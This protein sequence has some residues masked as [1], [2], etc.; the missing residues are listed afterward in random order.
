[1]GVL[2]AGQRAQVLEGWNDTRAAVPDATLPELFQAQAART[3]DAIAVSCGG[4][5]LS[6]RELNARANRLARVL[7]GCGAGP[8][9]V[10]AVAM[11]RSA[12]LV[13]AL[14]AVLK[15]GAAYLPVHEGAPPERIRWMLADAGARLLLAD[16]AVDQ[17]GEGVR[18]VSTD[19]RLPAGDADLEVAGYSDQLA[20]VMY[21]SGSTGRPKG[22]AVRDRD[23]V[24][25]A[26]DRCWLGNAHDRVLMHSPPAF[27]ASTY[28][29][30][31]P[32]LSG[33]TV[34]VQP[35]QLDVASLRWLIA[36]EGAGALFLTPALFSLVVAEQPAALAGVNV[37][38]TGGEL[39]SPQA[40]ERMLQSCPQAIVGHVYGPTEATTFATSFFMRHPVDLKDPPPIGRPLD[41]TRAFVLDRRLCPVPA[42]VVGEL[43]LAGAGLA[44]GYLGRPI[45]TAERFIACP[46]GAGERMYRT[47]DLAKW[48]VPAED[49]LRTA[50]A[51]GEAQLVFCGRA[52]DQVKIR[53]FRIE[54][55]EIEA[56]LTAYPQVAQAVVTAREDSPG[57]R[58][59]VAY[60]VPAE[61]APDAA[62]GIDRDGGLADRISED[63]AVR[64]PEYM[65]PAAIIVLDALPLT[66]N[67]KVDKAAL[68]A[69]AYAVAGAP[70]RTGVGFQLEQLLCETF[71]GILG[72]ERVGVDD[73]FFRLGGHSLLALKLVERLRASGVS[74]SVR[75]LMTSPTVR[76]LM[77]GMSL[78]S[79]N[80]AFSV[81]LPIRTA[82]SRPAL[83]CVHPAS[84]LSWCYTPLASCVPDDFRL[85]GLQARG[86]DGNS[87]F[88]GSLREMA[89]DYIDQIRSVQANGPYYLLGASFGGAVAQEI[90]VQLQAQGE[91]VAAVV[92]MDAY[93]R[94]AQERT[95]GE[96]T[97]QE[98][99][100]PERQP[101]DTDA[102]PASL[103]ELIR[104]E[105]GE[106]LGAISDDEVM[107]LASAFGKNGRLMA[108]HDFGRFNGDALIFV[109]IRNQQMPAAEG[110]D[111]NSRAVL[112]GPYI[113]GEI[114]EVHLSCTHLEMFKPEI[115]AE[116]WTG[117][118]AWLERQ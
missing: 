37:V 62:A 30:W 89:A 95:A 116:V 74:V 92:I 82:G 60:L 49:G 5:R 86:L 24:A 43:Y 16:H 90:A 109:T 81:L 97:G 18:V 114:S 48:T 108:H 70:A 91:E 15:T 19:Q 46:F 78:S 41:N 100:Q 117:I 79:V 35:G 105:A 28:E 2:D 11:G 23:V 102:V 55:G 84:G 64:L 38:L 72:I 17:P 36:A 31:V 98:A 87:E 42:G 26:S 80:D 104:Q 67:G 34:V 27:D 33:G 40:V 7:T 99:D 21:T 103:I 57:D 71:A 22:V 14:L 73:N 77:A 58:R 118:S 52:D 113:S 9:T 65:V 45:L 88:A 50:G 1:V 8:E 29:L 4:A 101:S 85:Y 112:W 76:E 44:R 107:L 106:V 115:L 110:D 94:R 47:G 20:Y 6:Y 96:K 75:Q 56:A 51:A 68:P 66:A 59:L 83:F 32:L 25:L 12:A 69:P 54:P 3:P 111:Q 13:T 63:L 10:V 61:N 93:P 53:G 39:A